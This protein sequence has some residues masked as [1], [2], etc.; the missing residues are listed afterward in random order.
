MHTIEMI[1]H[2]LNKIFMV[3]GSVAVM[4]LMS[5][6]TSNVVLRIFGY[7]YRGTYELVSFAGAIVI[8][9][10]LGYSQQRRDHIVVDILSEKFPKKLIRVL[11]SINYFV[12]MVFFAIVTWQIYVWGMKTM[13]GGEVM[14]T[15]KVIYHPFIFGVAA[16]FAALSLALMVDFLK[17][18][19]REEEE[20]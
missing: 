5:L 10:A 1:S 9:F 2:A 7:P 3:I 13:R 20:A 19:L 16:G 11:D 6:A 12:S 15:L 4:F 18:V 8:A 14:E 17:N